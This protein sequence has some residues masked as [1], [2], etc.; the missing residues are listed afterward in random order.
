MADRA[1]DLTR[2]ATGPSHLPMCACVWVW[3]C[4]WEESEEN[5]DVAEFRDVIEP[6]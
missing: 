1:D 4:D 3:V 5:P 2:T 6:L